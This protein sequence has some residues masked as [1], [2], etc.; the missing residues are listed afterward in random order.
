M[1][2]YLE[3]PLRL[4]GWAV[5]DAVAPGERRTARVRLDPRVLRRW[6]G[7]GWE[8]LVGGRLLVARGPGDVRLRVDRPV[9][10]AR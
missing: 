2:V 4:A 6:A 10:V 7:A 3:D 5:V 9:P 1:Q 8:P